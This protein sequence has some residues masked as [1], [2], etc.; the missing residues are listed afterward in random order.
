VFCNAD[1][2]LAN[3][4]IRVPR[5]GRAECKD[6]Q[7]KAEFNSMSCFEARKQA[8][9]EQGTQQASTRPAASGPA[10][11]RRYGL[12]LRSDVKVPALAGVSLPSVIYS[13]L[14]GFPDTRSAGLAEALLLLVARAD[15]L[16]RQPAASSL[17]PATRRWSVEVLFA[18]R[19]LSIRAFGHV[20][21]S[22]AEQTAWRRHRS[23][24]RIVKYPPR[25]GLH[26][27]CGQAG[28]SKTG[29]LEGRP[30]TSTTLQSDAGRISQRP[31]R[32]RSESPPSHPSRRSPRG[33]RSGVSPRLGRLAIS[34]AYAGFFFLPAAAASLT[35][36]FQ[37]SELAAYLK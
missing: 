1:F 36:A 20:E 15:I 31:I 30:P 34:P 16:G 6:K 4:E 8:D 13:A 18:F 24:R 19:L 37:N 3:L 29:A 7:A 23:N 33:A 10:V 2:G 27:H 35:P 9:L 5:R 22:C 12:Q 21:F 11:R 25:S 32:L 28:A 17:L 26:A 14:V